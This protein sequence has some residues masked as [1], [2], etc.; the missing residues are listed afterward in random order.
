VQ[1][2]LA[3]IVA[4]A[5]L[6][7]CESAVPR[8][9]HAFAGHDHEE[10]QHGVADHLHLAAAHAPHAESDADH[11]AEI[12]RCDPGTH[13]V[14]VTFVCASPESGPS[15]V[16]VAFEAITL[17]R[18]QAARSSVAPADVRAHGPPRSPRTPPRA[19]PVV[20]PA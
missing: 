10:H 2:L 19:P 7:T 12:E 15:P 14:S 5:M 8:H 18:P 3:G 6:L 20:H 1:R 11:A 9:V 16:A 4:V 13:A 17:R